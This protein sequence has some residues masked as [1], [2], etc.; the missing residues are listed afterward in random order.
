VSARKATT[1]ST[2][3]AEHVVFLLQQAPSPTRYNVIL[4][5]FGELNARVPAR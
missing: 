1:G 4:N 5:W 3:E 2:R